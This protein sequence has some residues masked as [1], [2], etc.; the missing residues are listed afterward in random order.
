MKPN[1]ALIAREVNDQIVLSREE[2]TLENREDVVAFNARKQRRVANAERA[3]QR[4]VAQRNASR[5]SIA[6]RQA[7][8]T[9][10]TQHQRVA[11]GRLLKKH[12]VDINTVTQQQAT[13]MLAGVITVGRKS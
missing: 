5:R 9:S 10:V 2:M 4:Q 7:T 12:G 6:E 1:T 8:P 3:K 13:E 11:A